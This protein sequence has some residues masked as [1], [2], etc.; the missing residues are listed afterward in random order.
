MEKRLTNKVLS[1]RLCRCIK[2]VRKTI[3]PRGIAKPTR[4]NKESAAIGICVRAVLQTRKKTIQS[5]RCGK[6]PVLKTKKF[7]LKK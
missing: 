1:E 7:T 2:K 3:K 5:F 4:R 6:K